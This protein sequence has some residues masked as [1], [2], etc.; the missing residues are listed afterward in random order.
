ML[1]LTSARDHSLGHAPDESVRLRQLVHDI[2]DLSGVVGIVRR[3]EEYGKRRCRPH[4]RIARKQRGLGSG[5][6]P[7]RRG[8]KAYSDSHDTM[9]RLNRHRRLPQCPP[10]A[11][12]PMSAD[13]TI[14]SLTPVAGSPR[15]EGGLLL[16]VCDHVIAPGSCGPC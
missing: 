5:R 8:R 11:L 6:S 7:V 10:V 9:L 1:K 12:G 13:G 16:A 4:Q 3:S 15:H 2:E 14:V